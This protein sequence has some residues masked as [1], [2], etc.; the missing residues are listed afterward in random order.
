MRQLYVI[1]TVSALTMHLDTKANAPVAAFPTASELT[2]AVL[3]L[4]PRLAYDRAFNLAVGARTAGHRYHIDPYLLIA[5]SFQESSFRTDL[6]MGPAGELGICQ[7]LFGWSAR[8]AFI[9][10]FGKVTEQ[11]FRDPAKS[12]KFAA[13]LLA[14]VRK[15]RGLSGALPSWTFFNSFHPSARARYYDKVKRHISSLKQHVGGSL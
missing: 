7:V 10:E 1:L 9:R 4:A 14:T 3:K 6:P 11:D 12:L 2:S 15:E 13:W 8:P 5:I